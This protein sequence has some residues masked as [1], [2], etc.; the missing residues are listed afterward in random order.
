MDVVDALCV[1]CGT[2]C[3]CNPPSPRLCTRCLQDTVSNNLMALPSWAAARMLLRR[4]RG[5]SR[6][7][8]AEITQVALRVS[9][10]FLLRDEE[11]PTREREAPR[12]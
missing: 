3:D 5:E 12:W 10:Y 11:T 9:A 8:P 2:A 6:A 4:F 7:S 1:R